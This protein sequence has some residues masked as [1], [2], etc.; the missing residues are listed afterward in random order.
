VSALI[1]LACFEGRHMIRPI[2]ILIIFSGAILHPLVGQEHLKR[3][4]SID[5]LSYRFEIDLN[6]TTDIIRGNAVVEV[7][8]KSEVDQFTLELKNMSG[9]GKGMLVRELLEENHGADYTHADD[10]IEIT[11]TGSKAGM[12]RRYHIKYEGIPGDGLIISTNKY[13]DRTFFGD[14][15]PNRAHH[16]LPVVDHPSDKALVEFQI[17]APAAY[18]VVSN[19]ENVRE[20]IIGNRIVSDW[21]TKVPIPTKLMVIG[22]SPFSVQYRESASGVPVSTWVYPQNKEEGFRDFSNAILPLDYF[23][24]YIA[25]YPYSKLAN[26]QSKTVFGGME[27]ASC[28]FYGENKVTG[29]QDLETLIAHE[30]AHQWFGDAVS[31]QNWYH[32]WISEGFATY[33]ADLYLEHVHGRDAFVA[34]LLDEKDQVLK[35]SRRRYAPIIDTTLGVSIRLLNNNSYEKAGWVLHMLRRELGDDLFRQSV[36]SFYEEYKFGNALT[37]DFRQV[38]QAVSGKDFTSFFFQWF[39]QPGHPVLS[40]DWQYADGEIKLTITQHQLQHIFEFPLDIE[41]KYDFGGSRTE[42]FMVDAPEHTF[43]IRSVDKPTEIILDPE[44]WLLFE[45][46]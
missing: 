44:T 42:T 10:K 23:E 9:D 5:V 12:I 38:V 39:H 40:A 1:F 37:K 2:L 31:E 19:G 4:K 28:I 27:N 36:R 8:F 11:S 25:P 6:D 3:N 32:V 43:R 30:I 18:R 46:Y 22:V 16:W 13:G 17:H 45:Y 24:W 15:W 26:V 41:M 20:S 35:F 33:L 14:N 29:K 34:S 7:L 21:I